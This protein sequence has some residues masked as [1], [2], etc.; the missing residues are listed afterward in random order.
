MPASRCPATAFPFFAIVCEAI[1][2]CPR[3]QSQS[4]PTPFSFVGAD[5]W[6]H[7]RRLR[8]KFQRLATAFSFVAV[9]FGVDRRS[10]GGLGRIFLAA[11]AYSVR[12][13]NELSGGLAVQGSQSHVSHRYGLEVVS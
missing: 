6:G 10:P 4:L 13:L 9:F 7:G 2:R 5:F 1:G 3:R 12:H 11:F 8:R